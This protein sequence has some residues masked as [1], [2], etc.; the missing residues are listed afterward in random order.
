[1]IKNWFVT[2]DTH[3]QTRLRV[4]NIMRNNSNLI[5]EEIGIIV[6]GD[7][8]INYY[9]DSSERSRNK[10]LSKLGCN[11]YCVRGNHE[12]RPEN[13]NFP[14]EYDNDVCGE[15]YVHPEFSNLRFF[16]DGGEYIINGFTVLTIGGAYS[17][18]KW[19]RLRKAELEGGRFS[20]WFKDELLTEEEMKTIEEKVKGKRYN[21]IFSHTCPHSWEPTDLFLDCIDQST[22]DKSMELWLDKLTEEVIWGIW[23]FGHFHSDR[24]ERAYVEQFYYSYEKLEDIWWKWIQYKEED[25]P[26]FRI[27]RN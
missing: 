11:I 13:L 26:C 27:P 10:R 20:G 18:D 14:K 3:G 15:V 24:T 9:T 7:A 12:E 21:F 22:V 25:V 6:L 19:Y 5:P 2:G 16:L 4:E 23:C 17:V 1:M 8:G